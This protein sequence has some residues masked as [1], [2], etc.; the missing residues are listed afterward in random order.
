MSLEQMI[1]IIENR[2]QLLEEEKQMTKLKT[3]RDGIDDNNWNMTER[4][5]VAKYNQVL[6]TLDFA[7]ELR[8][9]L[10]CLADKEAGSKSVQAK[11][12]N[13]LVV[14]DILKQ[15]KEDH[16]REDFLFG[17]N[18]AIIL[19][20]NDLDL[21][22]Q[23]YAAVTPKRVSDDPYA[24]KNHLKCAAEQL[25]ALVDPNP[26][27][28]KKIIEKIQESGYFD[29]ASASKDGDTAISKQEELAPAVQSPKSDLTDE[30]N[31]SELPEETL[32]LCYQQL[33]KPIRDI[34]GT[35]HYYFLQ[36]SEMDVPNIQQILHQT[37]GNQNLVTDSENDTSENK[38]EKSPEDKEADSPPN[39]QQE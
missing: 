21:L 31:P 35:V 9:E 10:L 29:Q 24:F 13:V 12:Y 33:P 25:M 5:A 28:V 18:G 2:I 15:M 6:N 14:Q 26:T 4:V 23:L 11:I 39:V 22:D 20:E 38:E 37:L 1:T 7:N 17:R 19:S 30:E 36:D 8:E 27:E 3:G 16:V 34:L 32:Q